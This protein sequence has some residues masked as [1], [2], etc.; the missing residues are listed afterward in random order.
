MSLPHTKTLQVYSVAG[1][2]FAYLETGKQLLRLSLRADSELSRVLRE[3]YEEVSPGQ[4]LD[5]KVW[6]T[7]IISGQLDLSEILALIDHSYIL[8]T[9]VAKDSKLPTS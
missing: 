6:N 8:A 4:K 7:I 2:P 3:R 9:Q 1:V 5:P